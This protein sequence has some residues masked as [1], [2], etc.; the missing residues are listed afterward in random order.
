MAD[1]VKLVGLE[2]LG[3]TV[4][5]FTQAVQKKMIRKA[6]NAGAEVFRREIRARAPVRDDKYL[7]GKNK[8]GP[9]YLKRHIGRT[10]KATED[11]YKV[12]V[13][14]TKSAFY[15]RFIEMGDSH[16][17]AHPFIRPAFDTKVDEAER[18]FEDSM[19]AQIVEQLG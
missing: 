15:A 14:P 11:S 6:G 17:S 18:T 8:R 12:S 13:G 5:M 7:K 2:D 10:T 16:Q 19:K 9:G 1:D 3:R 4:D